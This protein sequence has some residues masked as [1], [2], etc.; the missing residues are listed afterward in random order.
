MKKFNTMTNIGKAKY[1]I[2]F[3]KGAKHEDKSEK[4]ELET[5]SNKKDFNKSIKSFKEDGYIFGY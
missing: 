3:Y 4:W 1:V 2:N 5:F